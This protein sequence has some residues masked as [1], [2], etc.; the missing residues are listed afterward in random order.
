MPPEVENFLSYIK[1]LLTS[2]MVIASPPPG[3]YQHPLVIK[4]SGFTQGATYY[5]RTDG[6][7][8][9]TGG[10]KYKNGI[11]INKKGDIVI[12]AVANK[13]QTNSNVVEFQYN[14]K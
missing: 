7:D 5:Y 6:G 4:L 2:E 9:T 10:I 1:G 14:I 12:K 13:K 3:S 11:K 8:P